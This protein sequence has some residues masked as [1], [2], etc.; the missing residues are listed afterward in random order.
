MSDTIYGPWWFQLQRLGSS[1]QHTIL[2][3]TFI[4]LFIGL[5]Q[6]PGII[7]GTWDVLANKTGKK[8]NTSPALMMLTYSYSSTLVSANL[9]F[10]A[11]FQLLSF[12]QRL[13]EMLISEGVFPFFSPF[14]VSL[15]KN[16]GFNCLL[17]V[18]LKSTSFSL[19]PLAFQLRV[20]ECLHRSIRKSPGQFTRDMSW[21]KVLLPFASLPRKSSISLVPLFF[22][23]NIATDQYKCLES[24][25]LIAQ[26][27]RCRQPV[28]LFQLCQ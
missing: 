15:C 25:W 26:I 6:E 9:F 23:I 19:E 7:S 10:T 14:T 16:L 8:N 17:Y 24:K 2:I 5:Y 3:N 22:P 21:I 11:S 1:L 27:S 4:W 13:P 20:S 12:L 28:F 18:A